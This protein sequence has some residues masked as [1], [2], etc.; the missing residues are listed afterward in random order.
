ML[1]EIA[2][3]AKFLLILVTLGLGLEKDWAAFAISFVLMIAIFYVQ[4][5]KKMYG[6][7]PSDDYMFDAIVS[8]LNSIKHSQR[9]IDEKRQL[10]ALL[11]NQSYLSDS[12]KADLLLQMSD[13]YKSE[14]TSSVKRKI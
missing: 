2:S 7:K 4:E 3:F 10:S 6:S 11:I 1:K 5:Y 8:D 12:S 13:V 14:N 9:S